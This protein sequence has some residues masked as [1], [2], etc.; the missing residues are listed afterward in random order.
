M[1]ML[2]KKIDDFNAKNQIKKTRN[3]NKDHYDFLIL[4]EN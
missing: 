3:K 2:I 1:A 4:V